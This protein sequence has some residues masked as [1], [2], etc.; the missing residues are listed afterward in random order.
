VSSP[1]TDAAAGLADSLTIRSVD[2]T[3]VMVPMRRP[4]GTSAMGI[5]QAPLVLGYPPAQQ[6]G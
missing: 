5:T 2:A 1:G 3:L 6:P 4:L